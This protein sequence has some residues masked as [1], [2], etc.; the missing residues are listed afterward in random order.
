MIKDI[1]KQEDCTGCSACASVC[2]KECISMRPDAEGFLRPTIDRAVCVNCGKCKITC[3]SNTVQLDDGKEPRSFAAKMKDGEI[4]RRSSSGGAF[5]ALAIQVLDKNGA[6]IGAGFD[7][8]YNVI[9]KICIETTQLDELRRSKYA[10]SRIGTVYKDAKEMLD[11]GRKVLF[12][13]TPCQVGGLNNYLERKYDNLF[14]VDF[15]CHGVPSPLAWKKYLDYQTEAK[16]SK[17]NELSFRS[18]K[19]GWKRFSMEIFFSNGNHYVGDVSKDYFL[20]SF[21]MDLNL[22][23]SCYNC[24]FKQIHR[25]ADISLADFWGVEQLI[26]EWDDDEG[27]SLV[28]VHSEKGMGLFDSCKEF[29]EEKEIIFAEALKFNPSMKNSVKKPVLRK[30]FMK[31][32]PNYRYDILHSKY[33]GM[34]P[35][36]RIR[37]K[38]AIVN[39]II[40]FI[41]N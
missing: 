28:M 10:Q 18:K 23:P 30:P 22:R 40:N 29:L 37:R 15:I 20:R 5:S 8:N 25:V 27:V 26:P 11:E 9:H 35:I 34:S 13:G 2:P 6:V 19:T 17:I 12:C 38:L 4:R 24:G 14:T 31:D 41:L 1:C 3:P 36:S 16:D 39:D 21:I 7:G 33:C 32:L